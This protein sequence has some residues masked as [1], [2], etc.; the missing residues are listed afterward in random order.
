[1]MPF[2]YQ[3]IKNYFVLIFQKMLHLNQD[4]IKKNLKKSEPK[5]NRKY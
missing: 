5:L 4:N 2:F 1:M 3:E